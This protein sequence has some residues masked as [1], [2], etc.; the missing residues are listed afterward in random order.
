MKHRKL[1]TLD[2]G[3]IGLGCM[4]MSEFDGKG[5]DVESTAVIH[6]ALELC[7]TLL[8]TSDMYGPH[9]NEVLIGKAIKG[10]RD[11]VVLATKFGIGR[12]ERPQD[13]FISGKPE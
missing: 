11:K 8:D 1:G 3:A 5:D 13:R 4:G 2:V 7:V 6:R 12:G 10:K 9:T